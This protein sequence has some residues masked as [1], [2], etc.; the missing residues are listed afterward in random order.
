MRRTAPAGLAVG[1]S[2]IL[3]KTPS[4]SILKHLLTGEGV[5]Q[6]DSLTNG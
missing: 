5:Q 1:E 2:V 6:N 3:L 4:P